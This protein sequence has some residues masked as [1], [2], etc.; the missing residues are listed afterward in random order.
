MPLTARG[1][2]DLDK[3]SVHKRAGLWTQNLLGGSQYAKELGY[4]HS[5]MMQEKNNLNSR[6]RNGFMVA[7]TVPW[8]KAQLEN[9]QIKSILDLAQNTITTMLLSYDKNVGVVY[10]PVVELVM[11][12][13]IA[14]TAA[15]I[16]ANQV[17]IAAKFAEGADVDPTTVTVDVATI[18]AIRSDIR[19]RR[20]LESDTLPLSSFDIRVTFAGKDVEKTLKTASSF[21]TN[22]EDNNSLQSKNILTTINTLMTETVPAVFGRR[23]TDHLPQVG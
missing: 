4:N 17:A 16:I 2:S 22:V 19:R 8:S 5:K 15:D 13:N 14:A 7:P 12:L 1:Y 9:A 11:S 23:G 21:K 3:E 20:L 10:D 6:Y 18:L